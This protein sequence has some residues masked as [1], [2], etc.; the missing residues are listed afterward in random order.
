MEKFKPT[1]GITKYRIRYGEDFKHQVC[2]EY[3]TGRYT[4]TELQ[5]KYGIKGKSRLLTWLH[6]LGYI[7]E[8][9]I[10]IMKKPAL[11]KIEKTDIRL[12]NEALEEAQLKSEVYCKMIELAEQQY[13]IKIRKNFNTK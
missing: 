4:K 11:Q 8:N 2:V 13:K 10:E 1:P 9:S 3:L 6:E 7:R 5:D 12:L